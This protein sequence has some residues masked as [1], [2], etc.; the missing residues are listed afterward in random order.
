MYRVN[1]KLVFATEKYVSEQMAKQFTESPPIVL[2]EIYPD[3]SAITPLIFVLSTQPLINFAPERQPEEPLGEPQPSLFPH[4][5]SIA[6]T[7]VDCTHHRVLVQ[8]S[9]SAHCL[10]SLTLI[11]GLHG[12]MLAH[13]AAAAAPAAQASA[14]REGAGRLRV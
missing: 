7:I 3:T 13:Q 6:H 1:T 8:T 4:R 2:A 5:P 11:T 9:W 14:H 10:P 12:I